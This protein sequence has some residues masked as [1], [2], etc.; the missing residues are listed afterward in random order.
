MQVGLPSPILDKWIHL[1]LYRAA[2][3]T[4]PR[5]TNWKINSRNMISFEPIT[6][7]EF[8]ELTIEYA[9]MQ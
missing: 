6:V 1:C 9:L 8:Q 5:H 3:V 7:Y 4:S 2:R